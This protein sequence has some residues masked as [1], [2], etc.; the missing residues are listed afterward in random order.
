MK[1]ETEFFHS[2]DDS[3]LER[4]KQQANVIV[5]N[6]ITDHIRDA[7]KQIYSRDLFGKYMNRCL[8]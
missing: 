1:D 4:F 5:A 6:R 8:H 7:V 2:R 3:E